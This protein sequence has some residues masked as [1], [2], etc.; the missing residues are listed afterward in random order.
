MRKDEQLYRQKVNDLMAVYRKVAPD[1]WRQNQA[2]CEVVK[3][4][5]PR[6][7]VLPHT[8][9]CAIAKV[10]KGQQPGIKHKRKNDQRMFNEILRRVSVKS[11]MPEY[12]GWPLINIC[13]ETVMEPAPEFY[14][15]PC[16]LRTI[17][18]MERKRIRNNIAK[19]L[20]E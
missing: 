15:E 10:L 2:L 7:Y 18:A 12:Q 1:C 5:A 17:I 9:Y 13:E 4:P 3:H 14:T 20:K 6:F 19:K 11:S 16:S 8:A